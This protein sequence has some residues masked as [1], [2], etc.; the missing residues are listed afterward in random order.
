MNNPSCSRAV[1]LCLDMSCKRNRPA[2]HAAWCKQSPSFGTC[3]P[4]LVGSGLHPFTSCDGLLCWWRTVAVFS[5]VQALFLPPHPGDLA[6]AELSGQGV[7]Q[8]WPYF[9]LTGFTAFQ[10]GFIC[11]RKVAALWL[12]CP[13]ESEVIAAIQLGSLGQCSRA[14]AWEATSSHPFNPALDALRKVCFVISEHPPLHHRN[15]DNSNP[16]FQSLCCSSQPR[17]RQKQRNSAKNSFRPLQRGAR[18]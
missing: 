5:S 12:R 15:T 18:L 1:V 10:L 11:W 17:A 4:R 3:S 13:R 14:P 7:R 9:L 8:C 6:A 16:C 2:K